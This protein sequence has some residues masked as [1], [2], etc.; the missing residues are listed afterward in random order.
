M[1]KNLLICG[2]VVTASAMCVHA[3]NKTYFADI[4]GEVNGVA[5]N[6]KFAAIG[7]LDNSYAYL[8]SAENPDVFVNITPDPDDTASLPAAQHIVGALAYD[9]TDDGS[10]VVGSLFYA[11]GHSVPA[12]Y[13]DAEWTPLQLHASSM[14]TNEAIAI[15]PDGKTIGGYSFIND[16]TADTG[17]RFYPCQWTLIEEGAYELHAY[18][19]IELPDH[20]GFYPLTQSPDGK[21]M[22]GQ[23]YCGMGAVI[24]AIVVEGK[25][26]MFDKIETKME[27]LIYKDKYYCGTDD[28]GNQIWTS[29]PDDPRIEYFQES[30]I[31]GWHDDGESMVG[32]LASCDNQGNYYGQRTLVSEA[33]EDGNAILTTMACVYNINTDEWT[34]NK[35][36]QYFTAGVGQELLFADQGK[37]L[38]DGKAKFLDEEYEIESP[39]PI[40]GVNKISNYATVLGCMRYEI[41]EATGEPQYFPF[42]TVADTSSVDATRIYGGAD[43]AS[44]IISGRDIMV[45]NADSMDV[46][47]LNGRKVATGKT[48]NVEAGVYVVKAGEVT[49]KIQV[50]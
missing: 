12:Y 17:G 26:R 50:R 20:Q 40:A 6:G 28:D 41:N 2:A 3:Q 43:R 47:D 45:R 9:V 44:F 36:Y 15:T 31:N 46:Y 33:D 16:P 19:D 14:N 8:W 25:L 10:I 37:V 35:S 23:L 1:L 7:D 27:P 21:V 32:I 29:D 18:T 5:D 48:A 42:I 24:P 11:D 30:Y 22:A 13:K 38:I 4:L 34:Y 49:A 39:S